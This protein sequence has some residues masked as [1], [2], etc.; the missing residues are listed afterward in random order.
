[1]RKVKLCISKTEA[2]K[3]IYFGIQVVYSW[4]CIL[5]FAFIVIC[6]QYCHASNC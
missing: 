3:I 1:M 5:V 4:Y 6:S 2:G